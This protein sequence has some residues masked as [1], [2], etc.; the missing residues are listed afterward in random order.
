MDDVFTLSDRQRLGRE[1]MERIEESEKREEKWMKDA[2]KAEAAYLCD[3]KE[4]G[5]PVPEFN[6]LHSNVET[7]VPAIYNS[8]PRPEIRPRHT[9]DDKIGK[10]ISDVHEKAITTLIDDGVLDAEIEGSAQDGFMAG[11]GIVRIKMD[12]DVAEVV[13]VDPLTGEE[14]PAGTQVQNERVLFENVS[15]RDYREG[16]AKRWREVPWVAY[17]HDISEEERAALTNPEYEVD[18]AKKDQPKDCRVWEIWCKESRRVYF[19]VE[20]TNDVLNIHDDPMQLKEFFPQARPIQP[21]TGTGQRV[22]VCPYAVY[23]KLAEELDIATRRI[24]AIMSGLRVRGAIAGNA[25]VADLVASAEDNELIPVPD[26]DNL[27]ATGGL[28]KAIMW[29]PIETAIAVLRELYVTREQTK[30][31]IYEITGISDIVRGASAASETATAQQIKTEWG[32]LRIKRMQ[33]SIQSQVRELFVLCAETIS[34]HFSTETIV[35]MTGMPLEVPDGQGQMINIE[36]QFRQWDGLRID[37]ETDSTIRADLQKNRSEMS[38]FLNGT[39]TFF[40][41]MAPII[42]QAPAAGEPIAKMYLAFA[43]QFNLGSQAE[44]ALD[45]FVEMAGQSAKSPQP[46]AEVI[47]AQQEAEMEQQR[48]QLDQ[49]RMQLDQAK[50]QLDQDR[51]QMEAAKAEQELEARRGE[52]EAKLAIDRDRLLIDREK[53]DVDARVRMAEIAKETGPGTVVSNGLEKD[54]FGLVIGQVLEGIA[55]RMAD[56]DAAILNGQAAL[57]EALQRGQAEIVAA[58]SAPKEVV[59]DKSGRPVGVRVVN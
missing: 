8:T 12:A 33:R 45:Q 48:L 39:A 16:P 17:G 55:E 22:P 13:E 49:G 31:A 5:N 46:S 9:R 18:E 47:Q 32:S 52:F 41:T 21:I 56:G 7:I 14:T 40:A 51:L 58:I 2:E 44:D 15:W 43:R 11:R 36:A 3:S 54:E 4:S 53:T 59:R 1:W 34:R 28:E 6:I 29:W 50:L 23:S 25:T 20:K 38:E 35:K 30:Q 42:Q 27:V 19:V 26:I 37:V 24:R 10:Y 57:A